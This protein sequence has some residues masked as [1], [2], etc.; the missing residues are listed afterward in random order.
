MEHGLCSSACPFSPSS[1]SLKAVWQLGFQQSLSNDSRPPPPFFFCH[2]PTWGLGCLPK[3]ALCEPHMQAPQ[4]PSIQGL[5]STV[6]CELFQSRNSHRVTAVPKKRL[7]GINTQLGLLAHDQVW[8]DVELVIPDLTSRERAGE[9]ASRVHF[10]E[11]GFRFCSRPNPGT[12]GGTASS[13]SGGEAP[14]V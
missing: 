1:L 14:S 5:P 13:Q 8:D 11:A 4:V 6:P 12:Q 9:R 7:P 2:V 3:M 10:L